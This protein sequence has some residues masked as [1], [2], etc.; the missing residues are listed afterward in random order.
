MA[1]LS[2]LY[3]RLGIAL[4]PR[5]RWVISFIVPLRFVRVHCTQFPLLF[6]LFQPRA[7]VLN[8]SKKKRNET[9]KSRQK[10]QQ[11]R[12]YKKSH[13]L[14]ANV[15]LV[16]VPVHWLVKCSRAVNIPNWNMCVKLHREKSLSIL[17]IYLK[18]I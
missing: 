3:L 4:L 16:P 14:A 9:Q 11:K 7:T 10:G 18:S 12:G 8:P 5:N 1:T 17:L 2:G 15:S 6:L 13:S